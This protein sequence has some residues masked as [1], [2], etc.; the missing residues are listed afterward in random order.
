VGAAK[1][2]IFNH[3]KIFLLI[4]SKR[5][6]FSSIAVDFFQILLIADEVALFPA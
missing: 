1:V 4:S 3:G 6:L 2:L 5:Y